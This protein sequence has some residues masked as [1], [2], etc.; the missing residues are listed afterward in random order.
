[1][2]ATTGKGYDKVV[3]FEEQCSGSNT[4]W[5]FIFCDNHSKADLELYKNKKWQKIKTITGINGNCDDPTFPNEFTVKS[6]LLGKYRI[7]SYGNNKFN[8]AY[9]NLKIYR[10][11]IV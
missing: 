9:L 11:D 7:K 3:D 10:K 2:L 6:P 4:Q 1:M 8:T 5:E